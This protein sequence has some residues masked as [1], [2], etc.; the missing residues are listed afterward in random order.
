MSDRASN[1]EER[2]AQLDV[3]FTQIGRATHAW[4]TLELIVDII[5]WKVAEVQPM[6]GSCMT[7]RIPSIHGKFTTLVALLTL[8]EGSK[9]YVDALNKLS[10]NAFQLVERR[11]RVIHDAWSITDDLQVKKVTKAITGK[12]VE[13]GFDDVDVEDIVK[14]TKDIGKTM[15]ELHA[16]HNKINDWLSASPRR[17][18]RPLEEI[19]L[20]VPPET[21]GQGSE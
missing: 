8:L 14:L 20:A 1:P 7:N 19:K 2:I 13:L 11:N 21:S 17:W 15:R 18:L 3:Y 5:I 16:L 4:S 6:L 12:T 9:P 10:G